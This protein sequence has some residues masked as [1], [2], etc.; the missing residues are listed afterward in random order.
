MEVAF[1]G[2]K[3]NTSAGI[4]HPFDQK[5]TVYFLEL[6]ESRTKLIISP[7]TCYATVLPDQPRC[8]INTI[9]RRRW[10]HFSTE[11]IDVVRNVK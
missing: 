3:K 10:F 8:R 9:D 1:T 7:T 2:R 4:C 6:N 11:K 5:K